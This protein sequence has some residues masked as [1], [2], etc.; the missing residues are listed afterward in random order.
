MSD[1][2]ESTVDLDAARA[3]GA[4]AANDALMAKIAAFI[5]AGVTFTSGP[6]LLLFNQLDAPTA[7]EVKAAAVTYGILTPE[8]PDAGRIAD[9]AAV[10]DSGQTAPPPPPEA[11]RADPYKTAMDTYD[12]G[13]KEERLSDQDAR[14]KA[15]ADIFLAAGNGDERVIWTPE[16]QRELV[17]EAEGRSH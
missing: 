14:R 17:L 2:S 12:R 16:K 5:Q 1:A 15:Y 11:P 7:D 9:V 13:V 6:G 10:L 4:K 3:E 8:A